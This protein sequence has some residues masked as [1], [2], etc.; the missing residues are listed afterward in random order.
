MIHDYEH[1][2]RHKERIKGPSI[3]TK[4]SFT[5]S[6]PN[7]PVRSFKRNSHKRHDVSKTI[8]IKYECYHH[9]AQEVKR[10]DFRLYTFF[11]NSL[12]Q[13]IGTQNSQNTLCNR[14]YFQKEQ[15]FF[16]QPLRIGYR[17]ITSWPSLLNDETNS[18]HYKYLRVTPSMTENLPRV[19]IPFSFKTS[20]VNNQQIKLFCIEQLEFRGSNLI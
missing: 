14:L 1:D 11:G 18:N 2:L 19:F 17:Y 6:R 7:V 4:L 5:I 20:Y 15:L 16:I 9:N 10:V 13:N 3:K 8:L 12:L